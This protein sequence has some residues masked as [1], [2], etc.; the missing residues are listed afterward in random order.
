MNVE[1]TEEQ[2]RFV[3]LGWVN[4]QQKDRNGA[5]EVLR[6]LFTNAH[7][8]NWAWDDMLQFAVSLCAKNY[9]V[10]STHIIK[11]LK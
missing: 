10:S 5:E 9:A 7:F 8:A 11:G 6:A 1:L 2:A 3:A 4:S